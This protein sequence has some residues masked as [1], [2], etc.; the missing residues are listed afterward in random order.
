[1]SRCQFLDA[2]I[3][4]RLAWQINLCPPPF[5]QTIPPLGLFFSTSLHTPLR[6]VSRFS[7]LLYVRAYRISRARHSRRLIL[8]M[9]L[10]VSMLRRTVKDWTLA[11][12]T[13][14]SARPCSILPFS[15]LYIPRLY[16][17]SIILN[18]TRY[19]ILFLVQ[20]P[21]ILSILSDVFYQENKKFIVLVM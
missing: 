10:F 20:E 16:I 7:T 13:S 1:M 2:S 21:K 4:A 19:W 12:A 14:Q 15:A 6:D 18:P 8:G 17:L 3:A 5:T 11:R 9:L